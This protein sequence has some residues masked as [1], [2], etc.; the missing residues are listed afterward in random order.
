MWGLGQ[1]GLCP[2]LPGLLF[3]GFWCSHLELFPELPLGFLCLPDLL[4]SLWV[5]GWQ[6]LWLGNLLLPEEL[7][8]PEVDALLRGPLLVLPEFIPSL[9]HAHCPVV[10]EFWV[11]WWPGGL[12][13]RWHFIWKQSAELGQ[14]L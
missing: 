5:C 8:A 6:L 4:Q 3:R 11:L 14:G 10:P 9:F 1:L 13:D 7:G 2:E 12:L